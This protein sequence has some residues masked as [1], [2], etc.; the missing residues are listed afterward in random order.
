MGSVVDDAPPAEEPSDCSQ[1]VASI[2]YTLRDSTRPS[3]LARLDP[4]HTGVVNGIDLLA[5]FNEQEQG[6]L[7]V[8][9]RIS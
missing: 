1:G 9:C 5:L 7:Y 3:A 2:H 4:Q 8:A 6:T